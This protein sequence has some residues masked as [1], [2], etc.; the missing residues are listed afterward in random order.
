MNKQDQKKSQVALKHLIHIDYLMNYALGEINK[1]FG[2]SVVWTESQ[3]VKTWPELMHW[4]DRNQQIDK[5][6][7]QNPSRGRAHLLF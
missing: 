1:E 2:L 3:S 5:K 7:L 6:L 4:I